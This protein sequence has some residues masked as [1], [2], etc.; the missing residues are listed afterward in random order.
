MGKTTFLI[1]LYLRYINQFRQP[2]YRIKLFPFGFP[3]IDKE[4]GHT[5]IKYMLIVDL[6]RVRQIQNHK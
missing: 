3:E 4:A 6:L 2:A 5:A 1:N